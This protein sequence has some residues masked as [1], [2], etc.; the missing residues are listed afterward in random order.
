MFYDNHLK[1]IPCTTIIQMRR[2]NCHSLVEPGAGWR[3]P[4]AI[5]APGSV[6][7][8]HKGGSE[9][10]ENQ[11]M[12][13]FIQGRQRRSEQ[14]VYLGPASNNSFRPSDVE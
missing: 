2:W 8:E 1:A 11:L 12:C 4:P 10:A 9:A 14:A 7:H 13:G 6:P 3:P 5:P